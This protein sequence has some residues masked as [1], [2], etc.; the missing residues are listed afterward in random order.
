MPRLF[1]A[2]LLLLML[3][4]APGLAGK[5][6][7]DVPKPDAEGAWRIITHDDAITTSKCL[8]SREAPLCVVETA[9]ACTVRGGQDLCRRAWGDEAADWG[10]ASDTYWEK[11][12]VVAA[13]R[14]RQGDRRLDEW[15]EELPWVPGDVWIIVARMECRK[16]K[17]LEF[18]AGPYFHKLYILH[19]GA[20]GWLAEDVRPAHN[21]DYPMP[22]APDAADAAG[23][24][25]PRPDPRGTWQAMT[26]DDATT[27]SK[28]LG[29]RESPMCVVETEL[30]CKLRGDMDLCR[31]LH[32][33]IH[34]RSGETKNKWWKYRVQTVG[35]FRKGNP[36]RD[37]REEEI[38]W[39]TGDS[40]IVV[41]TVD[42]DGNGCANVDPEVWRYTLDR[43][44][45]RK[46][47]DGWV[48]IDVRPLHDPQ[49]R[50]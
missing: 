35:H 6:D 36:K 40:W 50:P 28:C 38:G 4:V 21:L 48:L 42:C 8:G 29:S 15:N 24:D 22:A 41:D 27:T 31:K 3:S 23:P 1:L 19:Q 34:E 10:G 45:L 39:E 49:L 43:Y 13:G 9:I 37:E 5:A 2:V 12:R 20:D 44:I 46:R 17:C 33:F 30:A 11:Y 18:A 16:S 47:A 32:S 25:L 26:H 14:Y 7:P